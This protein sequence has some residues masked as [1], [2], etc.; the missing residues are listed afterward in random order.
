M[1]SACRSSSQPRTAQLFRILL[2]FS[3]ALVGDFF[4]KADNTTCQL[5]E[6]RMPVYE[7][8]GMVRIREHPFQECDVGLAVSTS[9]RSTLFLQRQRPRQALARLNLSR[10][11]AMTPFVF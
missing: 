6:L 7:R 4:V 9:P 1:P 11:T 5:I 2:S 10:R 3:S 8:P